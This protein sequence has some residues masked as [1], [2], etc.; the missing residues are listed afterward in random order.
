MKAYTPEEL[1]QNYEG[2]TGD[3]WMQLRVLAD[4]AGRIDLVN[5]CTD[6]AEKAYEEQDS[7]EPEEEE[8]IDTDIGDIIDEYTPEK[9]LQD[10]KGASGDEWMKLRALADAAGRMDLV[11][12]CLDQAE[13]AY[14][15]EDVEE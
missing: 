10:Y 7:E 12:L 6:Q 11:Q 8:T 15:A 4:K 2:A 9:L 13:E 5:L 3:E 1:L 14:G